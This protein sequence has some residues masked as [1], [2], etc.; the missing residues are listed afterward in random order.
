[1]TVMKK[2]L[3]ILAGF[4]L[5]YLNKGIAQKVFS[6]DYSSQADLKIF[7]VDYASQAGW[8]NKEKMHLL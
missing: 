6:V 2:Y 3:I 5:L 7:I 8:R 1:M 4:L